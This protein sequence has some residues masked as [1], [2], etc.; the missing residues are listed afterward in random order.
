MKKMWFV[1]FLCLGSCLMVF[2]QSEELV[3]EEEVEIAVDDKM[4][5]RD[6]FMINL[7]FD[8]LFHKENDGFETKWLS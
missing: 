5:P 4:E 7:T 1:A 2:S 8:N 3:N 6:R